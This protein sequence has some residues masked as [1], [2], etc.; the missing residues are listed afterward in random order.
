MQRYHRFL[1]FTCILICE[2]SHASGVFIDAL[3]WRVTETNDWVYI[4][5]LT[6]PNQTLDYKGLE[7][8]YNT[9]IRVGG[10]YE[11]NNNDVLL[12]YTH[13]YTTTHDSAS[14]NLQPSFIGSVTAKP[15][16]A[17]LYSSGQVN[18][19]INYNI[20]D[21][22]LGHKFQTTD[23]ITLHPYLG[24][25]GGW[26][27]QT[28]QA[29]YQGSTSSNEELKNNF[30]GLG[31]K[32]GIDTDVQLFDYRNMRPQLFA[33]FATSYL[34]G[35]WN[36]SDSTTVIPSHN[37]NVTGSNPRMGA[38]TLQGAIGFKLDYKQLQLKLAYEINDWRD[39]C[40]F[41]DNDTGAHNNDL[42]LQGLTLGINY[43]F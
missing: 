2:T 6:T 20:I 25:I 29:Q 33:S 31:P 26:I 11:K 15:S 10:F 21:I 8:N 12:A 24:I 38:I 41:F 39:Q 19:K 18:Q 14:G 34:L 23:V 1:I 35:S 43:S 42:I 30:K 40:Q 22:D 3:T 4:N 17:Y 16:H 13:F 36:L 32:L 28:I 27:D 37:I 7:F 5:S 9:G